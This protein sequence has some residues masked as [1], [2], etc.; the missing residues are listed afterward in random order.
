[1]LCIL[2]CRIT[3]I[4]CNATQQTPMTRTAFRKR[5][6]LFRHFTLL[7]LNPR[8]LI[9]GVGDTGLILSIQMWISTWKLD[10]ETDIQNSN[11][12]GPACG[13]QRGASQ[14]KRSYRKLSLS[15]WCPCET[16]TEGLN[17]LTP[18]KYLPPL[19]IHLSFLYPAL[20]SS[21]FE[22]QEA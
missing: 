20:N 11:K 3:I 19:G 13:A 7:H 2:F 4:T 1:M 18:L 9:L 10:I 16:G 8:F 5:H 6:Y 22:S 15:A 12:V 21:R 14:R 17:L